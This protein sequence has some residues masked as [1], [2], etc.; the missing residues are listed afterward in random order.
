MAQD[1]DN[2]T[3]TFASLE[4]EKRERESNAAIHSINEQQ[5]RLV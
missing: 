2:K 4:Y 3:A 5:L 1:C